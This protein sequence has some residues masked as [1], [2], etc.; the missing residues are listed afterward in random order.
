VRPA[1]VSDLAERAAVEAHVRA[2]GHILR[3]DR[4][5]DDVVEAMAVKSRVDTRTIVRPVVPIRHEPGQC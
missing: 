5:G 1:L 3:I 2:I 4:A